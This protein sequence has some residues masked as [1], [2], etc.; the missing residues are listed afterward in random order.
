MV[1]TATQPAESGLGLFCEATNS[2]DDDTAE[3]FPY[4]ERGVALLQGVAAHSCYGHKRICI[5]P[6]CDSLCN[7][8]LIKNDS[9]AKIA[10]DAFIFRR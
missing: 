7:T 1:F 8:H 6:G 5:P 10:Q 9:S 4:L 2:V 3:S